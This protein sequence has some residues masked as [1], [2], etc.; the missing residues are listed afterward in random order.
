MDALRHADEILAALWRQ[1]PEFAV[2]GHVGSPMDDRAT[3]SIPRGVIDACEPG[4]D[5]NPAFDAEL[6]RAATGLM[7]PPRMRDTA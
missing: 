4:A 5:G 2:P 1:H 7:P 3:V 6:G